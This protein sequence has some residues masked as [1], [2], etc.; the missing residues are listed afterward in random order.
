MRTRVPGSIR[1]SGSETARLL[2]VSGFEKSRTA[3]RRCMAT[4]LHMALCPMTHIRI[5]LRTARH[6]ATS[7]VPSG[8]RVTRG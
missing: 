2:H 6:F 4:Q 5:K 7:C 1:T 8:I 3:W